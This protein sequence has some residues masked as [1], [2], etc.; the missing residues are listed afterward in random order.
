MLDSANTIVLQTG[1]VA[2]ASVLAPTRSVE[3]DLRRWM[4][5]SDLADSGQAPQLRDLSHVVEL[6]SSKVP[7]TPACGARPFAS[8]GTTSQAAGLIAVASIA[9]PDCPLD[10]ASRRRF[11][12]RYVTELARAYPAQPDGKVLLR[13]PRIFVLARR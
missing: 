9:F 7:Q 10:E 12:D 6:E 8:M 4:L 1:F 2:S 5:C 13:F 11:L 3:L